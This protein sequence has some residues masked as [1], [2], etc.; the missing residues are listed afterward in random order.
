M[1][2]SVLPFSA[3]E[4]ATTPL[5]NRLYVTEDVVN[6]RSAPS[7]SSDIVMKAYQGESI[8]IAEPVEGEAVEDN[9]TWYRTKSGYYI[10]ETV[11]A[12]RP[13]TKSVEFTGPRSERWIDINLTTGE[14]RA[15]QG[16]DA[17]YTAKIVTG[18]PGWET[19]LGTFRI[20]WRAITRTMDSSTI[21]IPLGTEGSYLIP[22]VRYAQ[23]ITYNGDAIHGNYWVPPSVFGSG[24]TSRGC[25]GMSNDDAKVFWDFAS[26][27]TRVEIHF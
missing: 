14:A 15:M 24:R 17:V 4:A 7:T 20:E 18:R 2:L 9:S 26:V 23:Y 3:L 11:T 25:V 19:P 21:G 13:S 10:S 16:D 5:Y 27:G 12:N 1:L 8:M 6:I 22:N